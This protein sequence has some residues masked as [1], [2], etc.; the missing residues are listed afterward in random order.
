M[1][2]LA[3]RR[4]LNLGLLTVAGG[5][6]AL[7]WFEPGREQWL[8]IPLPLL[9]LT[10]TQI[11]RIEIER[12][13]QE[14]LAFERRGVRWEMI[15]PS[16]GPAN[17]VLINPILNLA[18]TRC[19]LRYAAAGLDLQQLGLD[20]P[21]LRLRL[22]GQEIRFGNVVPTDSQRYLQVS[23]TVHLCP[24][25]LYPLLSSAAASFL[26][27]VLEKLEEKD[28]PSCLSCQKSK[29]PGAVLPRI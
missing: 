14:R 16:V 7:A 23:A 17:P 15:A 28:A 4:W 20:P 24:D 12:S 27:P 9:D 1:D 19:P 6:A 11:E 21:R 26:T 3:R 5:L 2:A 13:G 29:Q 8:H 25:N 18:E 22:N 10:P